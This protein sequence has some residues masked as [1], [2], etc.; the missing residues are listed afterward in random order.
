MHG[1]PSHVTANLER[2]ATG[3]LQGIVVE[4][5]RLVS[6]QEAALRKVGVDIP[7]VTNVLTEEWVS[8]RTK[9]RV[10]RE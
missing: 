3:K 1:G 10:L 9:I 7:G 6:G 4:N 5:V 2:G 8:D